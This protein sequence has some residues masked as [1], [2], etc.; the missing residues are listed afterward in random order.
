[1]MIGKKISSSL[2]ILSD[3]HVATQKSSRSNVHRK[4]EVGE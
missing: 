4:E 2:L 1:M 3:W